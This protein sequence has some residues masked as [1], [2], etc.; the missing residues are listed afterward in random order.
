[1]IYI[2]KIKINKVFQFMINWFNE[3]E[4]VFIY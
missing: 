3:S 4:F 1:M 2:N